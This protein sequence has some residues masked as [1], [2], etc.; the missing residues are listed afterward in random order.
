[1]Y[2]WDYNGETKYAIEKDTARSLVVRH[3]GGTVPVTDIYKPEV[4]TEEV[5][6]ELDENVMRPAFELTDANS[7]PVEEIEELVE[8]SEIGS[9]T[10]EE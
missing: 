5:M 4:L 6:K 1:M 3:L 9:A 10:S 2:I 8:A 7:N